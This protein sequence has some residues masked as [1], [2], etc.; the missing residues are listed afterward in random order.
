MI[1]KNLN[2]PSRRLVIWLGVFFVIIAVTA[3]LI[4]IVKIHDNNNIVKLHKTDYGYHW[5]CGSQVG[6]A[7][8]V[9]VREESTSEEYVIADYSVQQGVSDIHLIY[10]GT[11]HDY[12]LLVLNS[13]GGGP[14]CVCRIP[15]EYCV[16][17]VVSPI[18]D[19]MLDG[20]TQELLHVQRRTPDGKYR[21][22]SLYIAY[23]R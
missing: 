7:G 21:L 17:G 18:E 10:T 11:E 14:G 4:T 15:G 9:M 12:Q 13:S 6:K 20:R 2:R 3:G 23:D 1:N 5:Y 16:S 8:R 22:Y 19:H